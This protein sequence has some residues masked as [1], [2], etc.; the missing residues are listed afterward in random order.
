MHVRKC[1][2]L[3]TTAL[4][5]NTAAIHG[6]EIACR[7]SSGL[8]QSIDIPGEMPLEQALMEIQCHL[9]EPQ[10][11]QEMLMD[12][13]AA[14]SRKCVKEKAPP[15]N[16][17]ESL[18]ANEKKQIQYIVDTLGNDSLLSIAKARGDLKRSGEQIER[19]HPFRFLEFTF[20]DEKL[21]VALQN[22]S[23]RSWVWKEFF[24]GMKRSL[25]D[26]NSRGNL[27]PH[28]PTF[29]SKLNI[30]P[31]LIYQPLKDKKWKEF[32]N[33]LFK[34]RPRGGNFERYDM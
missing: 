9:S 23:K 32:L 30:D 31:N 11:S 22:M 20:E 24:D 2:H 10:A 8:I 26:E 15:R 33:V 29:A 5:I 18:S 4:V 6:L 28:V 13:M 34:Q 27:L 12:F 1:V 16:Y 21:R 17:T 14:A 7:G 3:L 19:I 25:E